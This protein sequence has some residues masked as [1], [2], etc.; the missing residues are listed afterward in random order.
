MLPTTTN[1]LVHSLARNWTVSTQCCS[2]STPCQQPQSFSIYI[3]NLWTHQYFPI[4]GLRICVANFLFISVIHRITTCT[5]QSCTLFIIC[6][7]YG[8]SIYFLLWSTTIFRRHP[9]SIELSP[10]GSSS[11]DDSARGT[12]SVRSGAISHCPIQLVWGSGNMDWRGVPLN[13]TTIDIAFHFCA[14]SGPSL[15]SHFYAISKGRYR[16]L[17]K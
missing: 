5:S 6:L 7:A 10:S 2:L 3:A 12:A 17:R 13:I 8:S 14:G 9:A 11:M 16:W 15:N 4:P 1:R